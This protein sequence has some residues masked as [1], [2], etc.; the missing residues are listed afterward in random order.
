[1]SDS[2]RYQAAAHA[3]QT[4]VKIWMD[5][6]GSETSPKHLRVGVNSAM[7]DVAGLA[8]LLMDKGIITMAEYAK[9]IADQMELEKQSYEDKI[10]ADV[11]AHGGSAKVTLA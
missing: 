7:S 1:M 6:D 10:N 4:G 5:R 9:A 2:E 11:R 8:K 3:M